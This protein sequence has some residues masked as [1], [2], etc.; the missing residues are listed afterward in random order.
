M[1]NDI[2]TGIPVAEGVIPESVENFSEAAMYVI[3]NTENEFNDLL[4]E[5]GMLDENG[6]LTE[7]A[8]EEALDEASLGEVKDR[9]VETLESLWASIKKFF[10][11]VIKWFK[12]KAEK[13]RA[14]LDEQV[15]KIKDKVEDARQAGVIK[16]FGDVKVDKIKAEDFKK[17]PEVHTYD[18]QKFVDKFGSVAAG[19]AAKGTAKADAKADVSGADKEE[20]TS[21]VKDL[22]AALAVG[23][24]NVNGVATMKQAIKSG[25]I[26]DKVKVTAGDY[27]KF[28]NVVLKNENQ[29]YVK[30]MYNDARKNIKDAINA[31]KKIKNKK[32]GSSVATVVGFYK[33]VNQVL[34]AA[35]ATICE[36]L[37]QQ[38]NEYTRSLAFMARAAAKVE[39]KEKAK[40]KKKA[41]A[42]TEFE[43]LFGF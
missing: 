5:M 29:K 11:K 20:F 12:D 40:N 8:E 6:V 37:K 23:G 27:S 19:F 22:C 13:A 26:G 38:F 24:S 25:A 17:M 32:N 41:N 18:V 14:F 42:S 4:D 15:G 9:F 2:L 1:T 36:V 35:Q 34:H 10:E 30:K 43:S 21:L 28:Y 3:E 39:R 7:S 33:N 31:V 16:K